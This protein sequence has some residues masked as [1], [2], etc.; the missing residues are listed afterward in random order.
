MRAGSRPALPANGRRVRIQAARGL[1]D[2]LISTMAV[3]RTK[4][5]ALVKWINSLKLSEEI[6]NLAAL[7]DCVAFVNIACKIRG[8]DDAPQI[9]ETKSIEERFQ[10][11]CNFLECSEVRE[12]QPD[13]CRHNPAAGNVISLQK[14]LLGED[15]ELE[16]A[17]V[18]ALLLHFHTMVKQNPREFEDLEVETQGELVR[19]LRYVLDNEEEIHLDNNLAT[20]LQSRGSSPLAHLYGASSD[21]VI[22]PTFGRKIGG[23]KT[24]FMAFKEYS[25]GPS[26]SPTSPMRDFMRTPVVQVRRMKKQLADARMLRDD[27]EIELTEARKLI[28]EKETQI[29]VMQ[30]RVE[31]L[32]KLTEK[33]ASEEQPDELSHLREKCES[34]LN[35]LRDTQKQSQ[36]LKTEKNQMERKIDKLEEE[37]GDLSY[38]VRDLGSRL[39]QS[40]KAL[41]ELADEHETAVPI[42]EGKQKQLESDL[43]VALSDKKLM[44]EKIQILEGKISLMEDQLQ[45]AG[46]SS[47]EVKGEVM[48]DVLQSTSTPAVTFL[49]SLKS[50]SA[51][52]SEISSGSCTRK[53]CSNCRQG[54]CPLLEALKLEVSQL[55]AKAAE[56]EQEST[57]HKEEKGQL[58][59]RI[60][61]FKQSNAEL[62]AKKEML[63]QAVHDQKE[64]LTGQLDALK[65][66]IMKVNNSLMQKE[67]E[68]EEEKKLRHQ[69]DEES[70]R[71]EQMAQQAVLDLR[72]KLATLGESLQ[73]K[74]EMLHGF[75]KQLEAERENTL[76]QITALKQESERICNEKMTMVSQYETLK[77]EKESEKDKLNKRIRLLEDNQLGIESLEK[78]RNELLEKVQMLDMEVTEVTSKNHSL[79]SACNAHKQSHS[80]EVAALKTRLQETEDEL[81]EHRNKLKGLADTLHNQEMLQDQLVSLQKT[82]Q[83]LENERKLWEEVQ[84]Q[85]AKKLCQLT[86]ELKE[87]KE[88]RDRAKAQLSDELKRQELAQAEVKQSMESSAMLQTKLS[89]ALRMVEEKEKEGEGFQQEAASWKEK[90]EAAQQKGVELN[91]AIGNLK[92]VLEKRQAELLEE[93]AKSSK[94]EVRVGQLEAEGEGKV[95]VPQRELSRLEEKAALE[96]RARENAASWQQKFEAAQEE[97]SRHLSQMGEEARR[98]SAEQEQA[99]LELTRLKEQ[100]RQAS[101]EREDQ[102]CELK[103]AREKGAEGERLQAEVRS[104]LSQLEEL[105]RAES[106]RVTQAEAERREWQEERAKTQA[107][108]ETEGAKRVETEARMQGSISEQQEQIRVLQTS[109]AEEKT[110][111][112]ALRGQ[113]ETLKEQCQLQEA[114]ISHLQV[115]A[116][117]VQGMGKKLASQESEVARHVQLLSKREQELR[118][119]GSKLDA[120]QEAAHQYQ[121]K[122]KSAEEELR[123]SRSLCQE[124][125]VDI[126]ALRSQVTE[127]ERKCER[128][129]SALAQLETE[130]STQDSRSQEHEA[131]LQA[132]LHDLLQEKE[133]AERVWREKVNQQLEQLAREKEKTRALELE[134]PTW[135]EKYVGEQRENVKLRE[136]ITTKMEAGKRLQEALDSLRAERAE[137]RDS[138]TEALRLQH[139]TLQAESAALKLT[140]QSLQEQLAAGERAALELKYQ[141]QAQQENCSQKEEELE[142]LR[143]EAAKISAR[144]DAVESQRRAEVEQLERQLGELKQQHLAQEQEIHQLQQ[145]SSQL[146]ASLST[147]SGLARGRL[148]AELSKVQEAHSKQ[149][150]LLVSQHSEEQAA[151]RQREEEG[152]RRMEEVTSKYEK[153]KLK[154][155]DDR[156]KFQEEQQQLISQIADLNQKLA[157]HD[158]SAKSKLQKVMARDNETQE[159]L[160]QQVIELRTQLKDKEETV[161][162]VKAQL[163]KA[164]THYDSKKMLNLELT[165]K[166]EAREKSISS[167]EEQLTAATQEGAELRA[168]SERLRME[169]QQAVREAKEANQKNKTLSA[170]VEFAD[171]QL[172]ELNKSHLTGGTI[173]S[174][175]NTG[176][177]PSQ[178]RESE[179]DFSKDSIE[180][181]DF[182]EPTVVWNNAGTRRGKASYK[183]PDAV[184]KGK[185]SLAGQKQDSL[186]SLYFTPLPHRSQS[187]MDTSLCSLGDL[188]LDSAKKT[189]SGRRRTTQ[190]INILM[191]KQTVDYEEPSTSR[192]DIQT[193]TSQTNVSD[194]HSQGR[195]KSRAASATSLPANFHS[196]AQHS[197]DSSNITEDVGTATLMNLPGFRPTTRRSSRLSAFG[198]IASSSSALY[199]GGCQ[200]E[201]DQLDDWNRIAELQRR[202]GV[203]P[204]HLKTSYPLE[205]S[206]AAT[207][208]GLTE[209]ELRLGDPNETLRRAT[210]LPKEISGV[211]LRSLASD[212]LDPN[213]KGVTTRQRK[214]LSEESHQGLGTPEAKKQLSCFPHPLSPK[215]KEEQSRAKFDNRS[216]RLTQNK[217]RNQDDRRKSITYTVF[218]TPRKF[219][220]TL[221]RGISKRATPRKTPKKPPKKSPRK[222]PRSNS[223]KDVGKRKFSRGRM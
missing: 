164:K 114:K 141:A 72:S 127:L 97:A 129:R 24:P 126:E 51:S 27:L 15:V 174:R 149:L 112:E 94:L 200:D 4:A 3:H 79:Q 168:E 121:Q 102:V 140:I 105:R 190:V 143:G 159:K 93:R 142:Q 195:W 185:R 42:W 139:E 16:M 181:S 68:L 44:E 138:A 187:K 1:T 194:Q 192:H 111:K 169:A 62:L 85:E 61:N 176:R 109:V 220:S 208:T 29:S 116:V 122:V 37:N 184:L 32:V 8:K 40:Q 35:R 47:S 34:L 89:D 177:G 189:R 88:E 56:L 206:T 154:I 7:Q 74:E 217:G 104:L 156:N 11:I 20:F 96:T 63:E 6:E 54:L 157:Q 45:V 33:Q 170:Q 196:M 81:E 160:E 31:R 152:S 80:V 91:K 5:E 223:K 205:S 84:A 38:T 221:I 175:S 173:R 66:E 58:T 155:L 199:P 59:E 18:A 201:P 83:E 209:D 203:C 150:S 193:S 214:R 134:V 213:W 92:E 78:E 98:K 131:A 55:T 2:H 145:T 198:P 67:L 14:I 119:L 207:E 75:E 117:A 158:V 77:A 202:N 211:R 191:T 179:A 48:G 39:A 212:S 113:M 186:E 60:D 204:P 86:Q 219:S 125:L 118:E 26:T 153:A 19:I 144:A 64:R 182:E 148:E 46:D 137:Q 69:L 82:L 167:L 133:S 163:E 110:L 166:L 9:L 146:A 115:Q 73:A 17:K 21:E 216:K 172:R 128:Q 71:K 23:Q 124:R 218:N 65:L 171:R 70:Q 162:H 57:L 210:L 22:S 180:L 147:E 13:H 25:C 123:S 100:L 28:T 215:E 183:T 30:Q 43:H 53:I 178:T 52:K 151:S 12:S 161:Q 135:K 120:S 90:F 50:L 99:Q 188:S 103:A 95:W 49:R 222:S 107:E 87:L 10:F 108:L 165:E 130:M 101:A 41:N 197:L 76:Q 132:Q 36:D 106:E 136:E